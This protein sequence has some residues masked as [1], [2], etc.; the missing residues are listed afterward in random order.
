MYLLTLTALHSNIAMKK[1]YTQHQHVFIDLVFPSSAK[2]PFFIHFYLFH[3]VRA[4]QYRLQT[5][6]K[7]LL[8]FHTRTYIFLFRNFYDRIQLQLVIIIF[9][10]I[11]SMHKCYTTQQY[12]CNRKIQ[13]L[14]RGYAR[15]GLKLGT[16]QPFAK[17][18]KTYIFIPGSAT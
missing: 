14:K 9:G 10:Q 1:H 13:F 3:F 6:N 16:A 15:Y 7:T 12:N 18:Y 8:L 2:L 11:T 4:L 17:I 5:I